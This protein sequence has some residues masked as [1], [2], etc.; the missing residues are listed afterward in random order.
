VILLNEF[1]NEYFNDP[2]TIS[3]LFSLLTILINVIFLYT[4]Q[5]VTLFNRHFSQRVM[6]ILKVL[7][8]IIRYT[9]WIITIIIILSIWGVDVAPALAGLGI[10]GLVIGLGAQKLISDFIAGLFIIFEQHYDVGDIIEVNGYRGTVIEIG[11]KSTKLQSWKGD[12]KIFSNSDM[13]PIINFS[14][15]KSTA[16]VVVGVSYDTDIT[17]LK[18]QLVPFLKEFKTSLD[19]LLSPVD[20]LGISNFLASSIELTF[21]V[22]TKP[23]MHFSVER[24]L[25]LFLKTTF[26]QLN[27][28]IPFDQLVIRKEA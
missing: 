21:T 7:V 24:E 19:V 22:Q 16:V 26:D 4:I 14:K 18:T 17:S 6:T 25:R 5:Q 23:N 15:T 13:S 2:T 10:A 12:I 27:I 8:S 20:F 9:L 11:L 3:F 28:H 1:I